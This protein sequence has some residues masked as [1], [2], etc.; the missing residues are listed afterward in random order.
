MIR[1][2]K[3]PQHSNITISFSGVDG[4]GKSTQIMLLKQYF[5]NN[6]ITYRILYA[7]AGCNKIGQSLL[8]RIN[9]KPSIL[10][11]GLYRFIN[12]V[13]VTYLFGVLKEVKKNNQVLLM[14]RTLI[15]SV[16]DESMVLKKELKIPKIYLGGG[17]KRTREIRIFLDADMDNIEKRIK[18]RGEKFDYEY[19]KAQLTL[20]LR[21]FELNKAQFIYIDANR[22][23]ESVFK[24]ILN[25][26][27][28]GDQL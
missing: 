14:D 25:I 13:Q 24:D 9:K 4:V 11:R 16:V 1:S 18:N 27:S 19:V 2:I 12:Y 8:K 17:W 6:G 20:Y 15:D 21:L 23:E 5:E 10:N 7:R 22:N 26:L 3:I 28:V